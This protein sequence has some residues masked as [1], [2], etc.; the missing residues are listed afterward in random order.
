MFWPC[1]ALG[2]K[3]GESYY[4]L[5]IWLMQS[6]CRKKKKAPWRRSAGNVWYFSDVTVRAGNLGAD[7][8]SVSG[9]IDPISF[10]FAEDGLLG[11]L[12]CAPREVPPP[13]PPSS[14]PPLGVFNTSNL[15]WWRWKAWENTQKK[16]SCFY[17]MS[18]SCAQEGKKRGESSEEHNVFL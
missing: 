6:L 17:R 7:C 14:P 3:G 15:R 2:Q 9:Q 5:H 12:S 8:Q 13:P 16:I 18:W 4:L 11:Y 1:K 10:I